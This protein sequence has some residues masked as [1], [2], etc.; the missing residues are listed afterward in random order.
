MPQTLQQE[1]EITRLGSIPL[2]VVSATTPDD[3]TRRVWT[4]MNGELAAL[5]TNSVHRV[6]QGATHSGLL[7]KREHAQ[8]TDDAINQVIEAARTGQSLAR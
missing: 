8:V 3:E 1:R 2:L 5:S 6:I 7:W 4:E